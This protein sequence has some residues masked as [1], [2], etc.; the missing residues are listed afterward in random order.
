MTHF[1][2]TFSNGQ[3]LTRN[4]DRDYAFAWAVVRTADG[5]I[6]RSGFSADRANAAKAAQ[7]TIYTGPSARDRKHP[8]MRRHWA[9]M[10]KDQG[11]PSV[12]ALIAHWEAEAAS[13]N[14]Q[15]H[16]EIVAVA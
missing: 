14:A 9:K 5:K 13:H 15:R 6:E 10:A 7:A 8:G 12:D 16:I 3:T 2:A 11:F 1:I 4:S